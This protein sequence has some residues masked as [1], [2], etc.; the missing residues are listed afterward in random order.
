MVVAE[1]SCETIRAASPL[2]L[3][4][5]DNENI[6]SLVSRMLTHA[7]FRILTAANG[8]ETVERFRERSDEIACVLL[9]LTMPLMDGIEAFRELRRIKPDV[10]VIL[11]SGYHEQE[12][13]R[14]FAGGGWAGFLSKPYQMT[15]LIDELKRVLK[16]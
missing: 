1:K 12:A 3:L 11:A 9:D 2:V 15:T 5:D 4:A 16:L 13:T 14:R 6:I 7:G 10:R 8:R